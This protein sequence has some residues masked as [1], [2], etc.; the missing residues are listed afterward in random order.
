MS[1]APLDEGLVA[2]ILDSLK[3][4]PSE[5]L[6]EMLAR[7]DEDKWSPEAFEAARLLLDQRSKG[8]APE[9]VFE[10]ARPAASAERVQSPGGCK[11]G[12]AVLAPSLGGR[13]YLY[14]GMIGEIKG[15]SA[16]VYFDNGDRRWVSLTDVRPLE[17]DV[18]TR[19]YSQLRG[20]GT[21][22]GRQGDRFFVRYDDDGGER[23]PLGQLVVP[24]IRKLS[25]LER[26]EG[27]Y[28]RFTQ[29]LK[30]LILGR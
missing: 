17:M 30:R 2:R 18:S 9:P 11:T 22:I 20:A 16:Y 21:V 7:P 24:T 27:A 3:D 5:L 12:D 29:F 13:A 26:I 6:R 8:T 28:G 19:V 15:E 4:H 25:L 14:P 1:K 10:T 23:I